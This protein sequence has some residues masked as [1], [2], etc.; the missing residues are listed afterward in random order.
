MDVPAELRALFA[1]WEKPMILA[2]LQGRMGSVHTDGGTPPRS[3][4]C[5]IGISVF[6]PAG[7]IRPWCGRH[8]APFWSPAP[9]TGSL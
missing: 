6:W 2:C 4:L 7:P 3:A 8:A 5:T 9:G 1:G